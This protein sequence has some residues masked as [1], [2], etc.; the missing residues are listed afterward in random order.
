MT[1]LAKK[2]VNEALLLP[3][4]DRAQLA[5]KLIESLNLPSQEE[6]NKAWAEESE[7]RIRDYKEGKIKSIDGEQVF[8]E[9]KKRY[10]G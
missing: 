5:D 2:F 9:I 1:E 10:K 4:E 7:R 3:R 6:I 8:S